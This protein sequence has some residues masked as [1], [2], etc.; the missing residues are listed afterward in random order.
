MVSEMS[1]SG[2]FEQRAADE[3]ASESLDPRL[4]VHF[5][6][7]LRQ[8]TNREHGMQD[9]SQAF[10]DGDPSPHSQPVGQPPSYD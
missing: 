7:E 6:W 2:C 5:T 9:G 1:S 10:M 4:E 3:E 8:M